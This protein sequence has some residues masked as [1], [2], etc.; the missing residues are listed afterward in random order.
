MLAKVVKNL[1][2]ATKKNQAC[3][4]YDD[5][6]FE[7]TNS[8][9]EVIDDRTTQLN[10][11]ISDILGDGSLHSLNSFESHAVNL[12]TVVYNGSGRVQ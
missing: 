8:V 5:P 10:V 2:L 9:F 3:T 12:G 7:S 11:N 4:P 6:V 1:V